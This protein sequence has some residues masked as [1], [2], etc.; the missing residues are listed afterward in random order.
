MKNFILSSTFKRVKFAARW[1]GHESGS[2]AS[3][4]PEM[5]RDSQ[6]RNA[7]QVRDEFSI[8]KCVIGAW[9]GRLTLLS[10]SSGL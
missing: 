7:I 6:Y 10:A 5:E 8:K 2:C 4:T 3:A 1:C 9:L